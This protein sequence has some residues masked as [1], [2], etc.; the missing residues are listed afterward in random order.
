MR[1]Q[2][3]PDVR[4][5]QGGELRTTIH[6]H[7]SPGGLSG[8]QQPDSLIQND[9]DRHTTPLRLG[10]YPRRQLGRWMPAEERRLVLTGHQI[11][12]PS[13]LHTRPWSFHM[14]VRSLCGPSCPASR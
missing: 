14:I 5:C 9:T 11:A 12:L 4:H 6:R 2:N 1:R 8:T 7:T 13:A 10:T 3:L